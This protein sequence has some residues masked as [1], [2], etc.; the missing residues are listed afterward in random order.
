MDDL[1]RDKKTVV[2]TTQ[3]LEEAEELADQIAVLSQGDFHFR[4]HILMR[5]QG[6]LFAYG[7]VDFLKKKFGV[8]Y[9]L[10]VRGFNLIIL[11]H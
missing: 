8:G 10:I 6:Q 3:F 7:S 1:R 4:W 9:T 5:F 2:F 11:P